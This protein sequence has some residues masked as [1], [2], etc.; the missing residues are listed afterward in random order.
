MGYLVSLHLVRQQPEAETI[1]AALPS[2]IGF[3]LYRHGSLQLFAIDTFGATNPPRYPFTSQTPADGLSIEFGTHLRSLAEAYENAR[4]SGGAN[5]I[6]RTYINLAERL[7][8]ALAQPVLSVNADDDEA[9]FACLAARGVASMI[10]ALCDETIVRYF[11]GKTSV[12][13]AGDE[14]M[15]HQN[16]SEAFEDF[17]GAS[18]EIIGLGSWDAPDDFGFVPVDA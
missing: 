13:P 8:E 16:A 4:Q 14:R 6:K 18:A 5:G 11:D 15:L 17:T 1:R 7:S 2:S 12:A 10:I 9:D 3:R